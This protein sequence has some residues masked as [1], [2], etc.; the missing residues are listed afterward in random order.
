VLSVSLI[1]RSIAVE[2]DACDVLPLI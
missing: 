2:L 1:Q